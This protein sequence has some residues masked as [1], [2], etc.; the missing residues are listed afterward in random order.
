[1]KMSHNAPSSD[2]QPVRIPLMRANLR[3][4][5]S[6]TSIVAPTSGLEK[7]LQKIPRLLSVVGAQETALRVAPELLGYSKWTSQT[8]PSDGSRV[9][10]SADMT[11]PVK[12]CGRNTVNRIGDQSAPRHT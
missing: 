8:R 12:R 11:V 5:I 10:I 4:G 7:G 3:L 6:S 2:S 9:L 1:M